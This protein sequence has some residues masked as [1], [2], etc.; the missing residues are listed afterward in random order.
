MTK[1]SAGL[2]VAVWAFGIAA[3]WLATAGNAGLG[4]RAFLAVPVPVWVAAV[5][6]GLAALRSRV[7]AK[8]KDFHI[9]ERVG[10]YPL[11]RPASFSKP[12]PDHA[13]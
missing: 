12:S 7:D 4:A 3:V 6:A 11:I 9:P 10:K 13:A 2:G 5:T 1:I 8:Y